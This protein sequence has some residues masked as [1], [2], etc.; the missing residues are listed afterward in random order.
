MSPRRP[1]LLFYSHRVRAASKGHQSI[2]FDHPHHWHHPG[3]DCHSLHDCRLKKYPVHDAWIIGI[4]CPVGNADRHL[5]NLAVLEERKEASTRIQALAFVYP[6]CLFMVGYRIPDGWFDRIHRPGLG[7]APPPD[8]GFQ[9]ADSVNHIYGDLLNL[10]LFHQL[11]VLLKFYL[12]S[13]NR[14]Q[15]SRLPAARSHQVGRCNPEDRV[16]RSSCR[17]DLSVAQ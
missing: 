1:Y 5:L 17:P 12:L 16:R 7:V 4:F 9:A 6:V 13:G 10:Q 11:S 2:Y 14:F 15:G 8:L 3:C